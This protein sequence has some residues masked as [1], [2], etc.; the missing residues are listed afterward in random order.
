MHTNWPALLDE[1]AARIDTRGDVTFDDAAS[2]PATLAITPLVLHGVLGVQGV[3]AARFLQGQLTCDVLAADATRSTPGAYCTPKGRMLS[4]FQLLL[5]ENDH[6]WLRMRAD[7]LENTARTLGK[8]IVF[9]KAKSGIRDDIVG[10]GLHG[11]EAGAL[12]RE[13]FGAAPAGQNATAVAGDAVILQRD[14]AATWFECWLPATA[15]ADFWRRCAGRCRPVGSEY[16]RGL[17]VRSGFGEVCAA[18]A[19]L[20]I[21]QMLNYHLNG[22]VSF[23]KGCYTGQEIVARTYYR[24]Q[25]KRHVQLASCARVEPPAAGAEVLGPNGQAIGNVVEAMRV[26]AAQCELLAVVADTDPA[27]GPLRLADDGAVLTPMPLPY[28]I[29]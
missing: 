5:R 17:I 26:D 6:Y 8:Y 20:F 27:Q 1:F 2:G 28:A 16:W 3:D 11:A 25:V 23:R 10:F 21:P 19:E 12:L 29:N 22:A 24:G 14:E 4:S 15:A 18:T 7:L 9:S 13:L